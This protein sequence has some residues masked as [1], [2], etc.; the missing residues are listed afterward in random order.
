MEKAIKYDVLIIGAGAAGFMCSIEA[1]KRGK[2]VC[3]IDHSTK[4][5]EKIRISGG[6]RCNFTNLNTN[7]SCFV[8]SNNNFCKSALNQYTQFDFIELVDKHKIKFHEKKLGQLF[9]DYSSQEIIDMLLRES[10]KYNV[11]LRMDTKV[12]EI[13]Y[14]SEKYNIKT[15]KINIQCKS[16]V[17][18]TGGLSI[19]K[20]GASSF[21]YDVARQFN[22]NI[23]KT[24]P[25]LVPLQFDHGLLTDFSKLSGLS[26]NANISIG[27]IA[28]ED[29][30]L[31][32]HKGLSGPSVL[33]ISSYWQ[34][35]RNIIIDFYKNTDINKLL[36]EQK[37]KNPKKEIQNILATFLPRKLALLFCNLENI[38]GQIA[39]IKNNQIKALSNK[40][41]NF[42][43]IPTGTEG[44]RMAEVTVGGIDTKEISPKTME[45]KKQ[46][47]LYFVGEVLDITGHLGGYNFQWAWSSGYVAGNNV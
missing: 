5:A 4:I 17:I 39:N 15:N 14:I 35:S 43:T 13:N 2:S 37:A 34:S 46:S 25:G 19:P 45:V 31:F 23:I 30:L 8:S 41:N 47:G 22:I 40:I 27:K 29:D 24:Y 21:G 9:C 42:S 7:Q 12:E 32:T 10:R 20:I 26:V 6:G 1:G 33:Q 16:L 44:Y 11:A 3:L 28:F 36:I 18:A 38:N